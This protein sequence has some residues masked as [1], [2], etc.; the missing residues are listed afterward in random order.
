MKQEHWLR[1]E[2]LFHAVLERAPEA[3][4]TFLDRACGE[5]V[6]LRRQVEMLVSTDENAGSLLERPVLA[7]ATAK[8]EVR[9]WLLGRQFGPYRILSTLGS[10]GM[11]EVYRA[12]DSKLGRDVAIKTLPRE[13]ARDPERL[14]RFRREARTLASLNHP[15][16]AAI[17]GLEESGEVD[18]L[19]L[20]LVEGDTLC[21]TLPIPRALDYAQQVAEGLET[22]HDKG[23][24]HRDLKP[25]NVKVTP[26]GR[27]KVL[28][29][30]LAKAIWGTEGNSEPLK[31]ATVTGVGTMAGH[32]VGTPGYMSPEQARG[33]EVD[34]RTDIWAFG[35]LLFELLAGKRAF[36]GDTV[37][38]TI[39]AVLE[40]EP[41]WAALPAKTP[42]KIRELLRRCLQKDASRRLPN[43]SDARRAIADV[44]RGS[45][46]WQLAAAAGA[47]AILAGAAAFW[48][49]VPARPSD[50]SEWV[51]LTQFPDPLHQPA[52]S[53]DGRKLA[54]VRGL[55][56]FAASGQIYVKTLP[57]GA[58]VQLTHDNLQKISPA[59]S[60]DGD[61]IAYTVLDPQY[62]YDTWVVPVRGGEPRRWLSNAADLVWTGRRQILF[63]ESRGNP[64]M[65]IVAAQEGRIGGRDIYM[66]A[67][68]GGMARRP[69][70]SPDGKW[71][72]LTE[73]ASYG[74]WDPCRVVPKDGSSSGIRVG[75]PGADC[76]FA[77]WSPDGKWVYLTSKAGGVYHIWRQRFPDGQS[78]QFTF[79]PTE[80]ECIAMAPDGRS[81]ITAVAL[82]SSALWV[83]DAR[84]ERQISNLEGNAGY[85]KFTRDGKK[86]CYRIVKAVPVFGR[87]RDP[88][89]VWVADLDSGNS[90]RVAPGFQVLDYDIS[91]DGRQLVMEAPDSNG[92]PRLW[93][94]PL[95]RQSPPRQIP[96]AEG[97]NAF[98]VAG[99]EILF[100]RA[101]GSTVFI[102]GVQPDGSGLRKVLVQPVLS[103]GR[104]SPD[105]RWIAVWSPL[106]D[107]GP[108]AKQ[109]FPLDGGP[110]IVIGSYTYL[111]WSSSGDSVWFSAGPIPDGRSYIVP[112]PK[113]HLLPAIPAGGFGSE[114]D[115]ARLPGARRID[116]TGTPG[117]TADVYAFE[118]RTLQRNLYRIPI[119]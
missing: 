83:H 24:I 25:T 103:A 86:L 9:G 57:D 67:N 59:F 93:L 43:I 51:Q 26:Q 12:H 6:E 79:G 34:Q 45:K 42:A 88:G 29:F 53:P 66:P 108:L 65:G 19:V 61:L 10:G 119:P 36:A 39:A 49:R 96:N 75:P 84:G 115:V 101:E 46:R 77:A 47:A 22:A 100:R 33:G 71:V 91:P 31:T 116:A 70:T 98:F 99:G 87:L 15:N 18:C 23:I 113:G 78:Q 5:D 41:D 109:V 58:P 8:P 106:P 13:F 32:I 16:I 110:P 44:Q 118:R 60:P 35:C 97:R 81:F 92:R 112:V 50:R 4:G 48:W 1:V 76:S 73:M 64:M 62:H 54:F 14:A 68:I 74:N 38:Q 63:A 95:D 72:V 30:G 7:D 117:P 107:N 80:E 69:Q 27:V 56:D 55:S 17:Y 20:E 52:L 105:G 114:E 104:V 2:E 94:A 89:E 21:G 102:Y 111:Q 11:G 28:D 90:E 3:R 82:D 37:P 85:P 40:G